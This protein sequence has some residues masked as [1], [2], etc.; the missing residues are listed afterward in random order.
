M[1]TERTS[2]F[3]ETE[4]IKMLGVIV[5]AE[6]EAVKKGLVLPLFRTEIRVL[7]GG[8]PCVNFSLTWGDGDTRK[9]I[10]HAMSLTEANAL[11]DFSGA[12]AVHLAYLI[13]KAVGGEA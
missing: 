13:G 10:D 2:I 8:V 3:N 6:R 7:S 11:V 9:A 5:E 1:M 4:I 12:V